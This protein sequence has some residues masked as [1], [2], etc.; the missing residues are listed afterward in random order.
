MSVRVLAQV[1]EAL[2]AERPVVAL[3]STLVAH[4]LPWPHNLEVALELEST[5]LSRGA[6]PATI[7][8]I[9]GTARIG[10]NREELERVARNGALF[11]KASTTDLAPTIARQGCA[12]TTVS[13]TAYLAASVGIRVFATGAIG[14]VHR[15][16]AFDVSHDLV[17]LS[18]VPIAVISAGAKSILDLPRTLEALETLG[19]LVIGYQC[20]EFPAFY[21][22]SSGLRLAHRVDTVAEIA[23][24]VAVHWQQLGGHGVVIA[25]PIPHADELPAAQLEQVVERALASA[26]DARVQGKALTPFLLAAIAESTAGRSIAANRALAIHNAAVGADLAAMI[27]AR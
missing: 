5:I 24:I 10:L 15:G 2:D 20:D 3:E 6:I 19:V 16:D 13:A 17:A 27:A 23:A 14:G 8:V 12:A 26:S 21:R 7:A 22:R 11:V 1:A 25:N 4:G 18:R 9:D